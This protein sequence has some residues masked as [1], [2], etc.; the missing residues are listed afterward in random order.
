MSYGEHQQMMSPKPEDTKTDDMMDLSYIVITT[1]PS[2]PTKQ[3]KRQKTY[4]TNTTNILWHYFSLSPPPRKNK[5]ISV[6]AER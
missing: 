2:F 5:M 6:K 3:N 1:I 4:F